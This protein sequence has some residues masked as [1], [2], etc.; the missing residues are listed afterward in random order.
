[1]A[2]A[3]ALHEVV[4]PP[5]PDG[6][7]IVTCVAEAQVCARLR[8]S[9]RDR[10]VVRTVRTLDDV[11][12]ILYSSHEAVDVVVLPA[13][14]VALR[15]SAGFVRDVSKSFPDV[16]LVAYCGLGS[17]YSS[18]IRN[19]AI[20]GVHHFFFGGEQDR[21][22]L[23]SVLLSA[24]QECA[25]DRVLVALTGVLNDVL[26]PLARACLA[27]PTEVR[28]VHD[29]VDALGLHR[30]TLYNYCRQGGFSGP[31][32][33]MAWVR[34]ALFAHLMTRS[35]RT[36][37][38]IANELEFASPTALRNMVKRYTGRTAGEI[39]VTGGMACVIASL[40]LRLGKNRELHLV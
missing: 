9:V 19:L 36:I 12:Q 14:D 4:S 17:Q 39:R 5:S 2:G 8:D 7:L 23:R 27:R 30:K 15:D 24:R 25:S 26:L 16:A 29:L 40:N 33:L 34:L 6:L 10:G 3:V 35:G 21:T 11:A 32:E 1:M 28:S 31:A 13:R 20:A 38:S 22:T 18:D 37:E